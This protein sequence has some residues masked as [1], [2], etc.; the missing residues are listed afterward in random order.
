MSSW[1]IASSLLVWSIVAAAETT[2]LSTEYMRDSV[3]I[4]T[5]KHS[6]S[7]TKYNLNFQLVET[8]VLRGVN[9]EAEGAHQKYRCA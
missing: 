4:L 6:E 9:P 1:I 2:T 8:H 7:T 3:N 5:R